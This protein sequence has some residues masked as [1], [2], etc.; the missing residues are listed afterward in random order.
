MASFN[1]GGIYG[2]ITFEQV[3]TSSNNVTITVSLSGLPSNSSLPWHVHQFP[4]NVDLL[5]S[6][7]CS[8][9]SV[10]GHFDPDNRAGNL[11]A[12][13]SQLCASDSDL[14]CEVGDLS[15][16]HGGLRN[17]T[18]YDDKLWLSSSSRSIAGRSIV[19]HHANGSRWVCA[20]IGYSSSVVRTGIVRLEGSVRGSVVFR[21]ASGSNDTSIMMRLF[22]SQPLGSL[23]YHV[24]ENHVLGNTA[25]IGDRC[26]AS[27]GHFDPLN[28]SSSLNYSSECSVASSELCEVGD[29]SGKHGSLSAV[30]GRFLNVFLT[31]TYLPLSGVNSIIGRSVVFHN[32]SGNRI[33]CSNI[34]ELSSRSAVAEFNYMGVRGQV[35]FDQSSPWDS[36]VVDVNLTGLNGIAGGYHVHKWPVPV[37]DIVEAGVSSVS[38]FCGPSAVGGHYNPFDASYPLPAKS[39]TQDEYEVGD[40]SGKFGDLSGLQNISMK[41][42]DS[43]L[44]LFGVYSVVGRSI[45]VHRATGGGRWICA[46]ILPSSSRLSV[47]RASF[48][49]SVVGSIWFIQDQS[50]KPSDTI[51]LSSL[52]LLSSNGS[53]Q[54]RN[55]HVHV[56][57]V[58]NDSLSSSTSRCSS[59][60]GHFNPQNV[61]VNTSVYSC[62]PSNQLLCEVGDLVS[63]SSQ[64]VLNGMSVSKLLYTDIDLPVSSMRNGILGKSVV[65]HGSEYGGRLACADI[66]SVGVRRGVASL[67]SMGSV[68]VE[69]MSPLSAS[70]I[71]VNLNGLGGQAGG[72]H[73]HEL[74]L[75]MS[76][77]CSSTGGHFN[78]LGVVYGSAGAP[79]LGNSNSTLDAY[80]SGD[81]SGKFGSLSGLNALKAQYLDPRYVP[82]YGKL[83][84]IGRSVVVHYSN[85]TRWFCADIEDMNRTVVVRRALISSSSLSGSITFSQYS[86]SETTSI[87]INLSTTNGS[88]LS[89]NFTT[90]YSWLL[91]SSN[92]AGCSG[93]VIDTT[94]VMQDSAYMQRCRPSSP[95]L[96]SVGDLSGKVGNITFSSG[97]NSLRQFSMTGNVPLFGRNSGL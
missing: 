16:R 23:T 86:G 33:A 10:G 48:S 39:F 63:K 76:G 51:V 31:D 50:S 30:S 52:Q 85:G 4:L 42:S 88:A 13:Y 97:S 65:I 84:V 44:T 17:T 11:G 24:H 21:Q 62:S 92:G 67:G 55:W 73:I 89:S 34:L 27:G 80:E 71:D 74:P 19:I 95:L 41:Y 35:R 22:Y 40:L 61:D 82:M 2:D 47:G 32:S 79:V 87:L 72:Y 49:G 9:S 26:A 28:A 8:A 70:V 3:G 83:N 36:V 58:G 7:R 38:E 1:S 15:G 45:V 66:V 96:C 43:Y 5:P 94:G 6:Q 91:S 53:S 90:L 14:N 25:N 78:P 46:S 64:L 59:C 77:S 75:S 57:S 81:L 12:N 37:L 68:G 93:N 18:Y 56:N 20:S 29:L 69:S 60:G 54:A